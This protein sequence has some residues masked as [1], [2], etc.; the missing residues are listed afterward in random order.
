MIRAVYSTG[1]K[2][3]SIS[4]GRIDEGQTYAPKLLE[5]LGLA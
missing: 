1:R 5:V 2:S 3:V 4:S